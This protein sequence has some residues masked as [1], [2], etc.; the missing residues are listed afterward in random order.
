MFPTSGD[1]KVQAR[2]EYKATDTTL[3]QRPLHIPFPRL[4]YPLAYAVP[5]AEDDK[6]RSHFG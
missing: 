6:G 5:Y 3:P 2:T 1:E 4:F